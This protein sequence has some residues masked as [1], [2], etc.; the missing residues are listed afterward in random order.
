MTNGEIR[1]AS[2]TLARALT[3]HENMGISPRVNVVRMNP[4]IF[5]GSK[6]WKN[7]QEFLDE[8]YKIVH[9]VVVTSKEKEELAS[10]Q[11]KDV[12]QV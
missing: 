2:L 10:Y 8:M 5:V 3:T 9:V 7:P 11:L 12:T 1:E 4:P 6:V